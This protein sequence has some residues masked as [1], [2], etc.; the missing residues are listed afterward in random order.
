MET[1]KIEVDR[2]ALLTA[3]RNL[4]SVVVSLDRIGATASEVS[5]EEYKETVVHFLH[6]WKVFAKLAE[7]RRLLSD[8]FGNEVGDDGM[9]ELERE[10]DSVEYW[11]YKNYRASQ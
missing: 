2:V 11:S 3:L 4:E 8:P 1:N 5:P 9:D 10:L 7:A 6:D